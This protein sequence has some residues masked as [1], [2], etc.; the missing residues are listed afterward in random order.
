[1]FLLCT[2]LCRPKTQL[3]VN[4]APDSD[5][6]QWWHPRTLNNLKGSERPIKAQLMG[7]HVQSKSV[8]DPNL[9][10]QHNKYK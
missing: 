8:H 2:E 3:T 7:R 4:T 1:M 5:S 6:E 9:K 10:S